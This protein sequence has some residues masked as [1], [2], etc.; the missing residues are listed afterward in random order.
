VYETICLE[1]ARPGFKALY[2][3]GKFVGSWENQI[4]CAND[5]NLLNGTINLCLYKKQKTYKG[6]I[7]EYIGDNYEQ[8]YRLGS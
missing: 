8:S 7:F 2:K 3:K 5:L 4:T 1:K 6:L